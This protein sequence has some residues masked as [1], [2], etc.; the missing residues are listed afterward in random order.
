MHPSSPVSVERVRSKSRKFNNF[1]LLQQ[2]FG[3]KKLMQPGFTDT[4]FRFAHLSYVQIV[5][6]RETHPIERLAPKMDS[7]TNQKKPGGQERSM[8]D[9]EEGDAHAPHVDLKFIALS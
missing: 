4:H 2:S 9:H 1:A 8:H 5:P 6:N 7:K 3:K